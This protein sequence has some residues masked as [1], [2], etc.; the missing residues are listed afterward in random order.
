MT[1]AMDSNRPT[2]VGNLVMVSGDVTGGDLGGNTFDAS[3]YM[4]E[5]ISAQV[6]CAGQINPLISAHGGDDDTNVT[7]GFILNL[8][9][10]YCRFSGTTLFVLSRNVVPGLADEGNPVGLLFGATPSMSETTTLPS[11]GKF[12]IIGRK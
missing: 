9:A 5:I 6:L 10:L 7:S 2:V 4:N 3:P 8:P 1:V 11:N 12:L